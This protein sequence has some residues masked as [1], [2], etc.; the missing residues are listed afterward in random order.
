MG[1]K[2]LEASLID[3]Q[4]VAKKTVANRSRTGRGVSVSR[5]F[6]IRLLG[7]RPL[8]FQVMDRFFQIHTVVQMH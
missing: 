1:I 5:A 4:S 3:R 6:D 7:S 8:F 2:W